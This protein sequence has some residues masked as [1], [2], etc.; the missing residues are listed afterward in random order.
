MAI[1]YVDATKLDNSLAYTANRIRAKT[2]GSSALNF[3]LANETGFGDDVDAI[4]S[5]GGSTYTEQSVTLTLASRTSMIDILNAYVK[6]CAGWRIYPTDSS[7]TATNTI[8]VGSFFKQG[9]GTAP[10]PFSSPAT[11]GTGVTVDGGIA[12]F[13]VNDQTY[14]STRPRGN[15]NY[16]PAGTYQLDFYGVAKT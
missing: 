7:N 6:E 3:D 2:G 11:S 10:S 9:T 4:P 5:G 14:S 16:K 13:T 1:E 8:A 15:V 12:N